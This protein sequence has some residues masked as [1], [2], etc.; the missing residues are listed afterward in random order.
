MRDKSVKIAGRRKTFNKNSKH[1][2]KNRGGETEKAETRQ[3]DAGKDISK[4]VHYIASFCHAW[5]ITAPVLETLSLFILR[6]RKCW[7]LFSI[8]TSQLEFHLLA[9]R[10]PLW[11]LP[12]ASPEAADWCWVSFIQSIL[13]LILEHINLHLSKTAVTTHAI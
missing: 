8:K 7:D 10:F 12:P 5:S 6:C 2:N 11:L 13:K 1:A 4:Q 3:Q 9:G